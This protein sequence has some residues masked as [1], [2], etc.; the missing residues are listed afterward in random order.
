M[1][2]TTLFDLGIGDSLG[3]IR[4]ILKHYRQFHEICDYKQYYTTCYLG[5]C[6]NVYA[7]YTLYGG[8]GIFND[9][10]K[11]FSFTLC[12][13]LKSYITFRTS[14]GNIRLVSDKEISPPTR[15]SFCGRSWKRLV[16]SKP[17]NTICSSISN[18]LQNID[19][20]QWR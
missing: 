18:K 9:T 6:K 15:T 1:V 10:Y 2:H 16:S 13:R 14:L 17:I 11:M 3:L 7:L 5:V 4:S 20:S 19:L 8:I 12:K